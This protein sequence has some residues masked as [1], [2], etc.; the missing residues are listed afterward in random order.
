MRPARDNVIIIL[1]NQ[2]EVTSGGI[3]LPKSQQDKSGSGVVHSVGVHKDGSKI[4]LS[5]GERVFFNRYAGT[6]FEED[7]VKCKVIKYDLLY[8][9]EDQGLKVEAEPWFQTET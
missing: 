8:A 7:G 6:D 5:A 4:D 2:E 9:R 3:I 1:D